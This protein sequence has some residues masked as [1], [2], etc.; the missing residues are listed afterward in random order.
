MLHRV[1]AVDAK[2]PSAID[3]SV[4][5]RLKQRR[6]ELNLSQGAVAEKLGVT[7]QQL[8]KYEQGR[9]RISAGRLFQLAQLL[10]TTIQYFYEGS[11]VIAQ[12]AAGLAEEGASF[13]GP[14]SNEAVDLVIA[15]ARISEPD[16]RESILST[17]KAAAARESGATHNKRSRPS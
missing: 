8:Q 6:L 11:G 2:D 7:F 4:A 17:A 1:V 14:V 9:N 10:G 16:L 3:L 13:E 12:A 15:F 5:H